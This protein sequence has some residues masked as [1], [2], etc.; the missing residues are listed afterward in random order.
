MGQPRLNL[1]G[2]TALVVDSDRFT[3]SLV[4]QMLRGFGLDQ[5]GVCETGAAAIAYM[6]NRYVDLCVIEAVLPDME[7][8]E[9]IGWIRKQE[10]AMRFI[11]IIVL[12]GYTQLRMVSAARDG[13]ANNVVKKP[14][15]AQGLFD[16]V[17]WVARVSRPFIEAGN[18][19]G[20]DR[21]FRNI[22]P[23]DGQFKRDGDG[24]RAF[25]P[26][27]ATPDSV[28]RLAQAMGKGLSL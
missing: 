15:S 21:R 10:K 25:D 4:T 22:D 6:Q 16:R 12:T 28:N 17:T 5:P 26:K 18:Y 11:P 9:L 24:G 1:K 2:V 23:P 20:P 13:G 19:V 3:R 27:A 14:V 8:P 7:S